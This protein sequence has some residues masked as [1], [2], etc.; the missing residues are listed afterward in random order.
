MTLTTARRMVMML[1]MSNCETV[2]LKGALEIVEAL[3]K[4]IERLNAPR[5]RRQ[6]QRISPD[7]PF[8]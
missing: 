3:E 1:K 8:A 2:E 6:K 7:H 5:V 4:E